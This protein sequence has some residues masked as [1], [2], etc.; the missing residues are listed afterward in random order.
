MTVDRSCLRNVAVS[1]GT[2]MVFNHGRA[3]AIGQPPDAPKAGQIR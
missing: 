2:N 3:A 1:I